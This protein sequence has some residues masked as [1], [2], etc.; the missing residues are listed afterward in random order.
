MLRLLR[1]IPLYLFCLLTAAAHAQ[2]TCR[3][4][5]TQVDTANKLKGIEV[6]TTF[7]S[8]PACEQ[9]VQQLPGMLMAA[10]YISASIDSLNSDSSGMHLQLFVG[11]KY[12]WDDLRVSEED[13]YV[14]NTLG[15]NKATFHN[16]P[17]D[18]GKVEL[19]YN[20]LLDYFANNGYPFARVG[21]DSITMNDEKLQ[22]KLMVDKGLLYHIDSIIIDGS[23][24]MSPN[25]IYHYLGIKPHDVYQQNKLD[26]INQRLAELPYLEQQE[27]WRLRMLSQGAEVTL[28]LQARRSNQVDIL[29]GFLPSNQ[30][31]SG[32]L[33]VTGNATLDLRNPFGNGETVGINW[34]QLQSKSPRL[35]LVFQRPYIFR[36]PFGFNFNFELYKKDSTY[37]NING[38]AGLQY[39]LSSRQSGA[40]YIQTQTTKVVSVDTALVIATKQ[41]PPV[42]DATSISLALQYEF[43]NTNYRF[44]PRSGNELQ[45]VTS[46]GSKR[47]KK[48]SDILQ[49]K[50][51]TFNYASLYDTIKANSYIV[52]VRL[53][54]AHYFPVGKQ[55]T[56]KTAVNGGWYQS[57]NYFQNELFQIGG[58]KLLR[59]FDEESIFTN[60][61]AAGTAE[62]HYLLG[63]N[64]Y[65]FGFA[66]GGWARYE[67]ILT[68]FSHTYLG[69]GLGLAFETKT[70]VFNISFAEGK[71]DDTN[72]NF[73]QAKI[74]LGFI[75]VF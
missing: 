50:D 55:S 26:K 65:L 51:P 53:S 72:F 24:K 20:Q 70:G 41:L 6:K 35:N 63:Q 4:V 30:T 52:K 66:D 64:S 69:L 34:Q 71:R 54:A 49:I 45:L 58:Y 9:Y 38:Q 47:I 13:W 75:S 17:F 46:F 57:P 7:P 29:V 60:R 68:S 10:G 14:L 11:K 18:H 33:L 22:A 23:V 44:N 39:L 67:T 43:N 2:K 5:I 19:V 27:P 1:F 25:F 74:H 15:Y 61:F 21:I 28:S 73:R 32:K 37:L 40:V 59:G 36:S 42:I 3:L 48:S 56:I 62:Y 31:T 8:K 12:I 16:K